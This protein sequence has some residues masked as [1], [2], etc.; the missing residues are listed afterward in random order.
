MCEIREK[1]IGFFEDYVIELHNRN[2]IIGYELHDT[3]EEVSTREIYK[4]EAIG[5][6]I[7]YL[8]NETG[9]II[10]FPANVVDDYEE[11]DIIEPGVSF[12]QIAQFVHG[13]NIT[14]EAKENLLDKIFLLWDDIQ[15]YSLYQQEEE[16][17][18]NILLEEVINTDLY[19]KYGETL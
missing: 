5:D 16:E 18:F 6:N 9:Y 19:D 17:L 3:I 7:Y 14:E 2:E 11:F 1:V 13:M 4:V 8:K 12:A 15:G 10:E